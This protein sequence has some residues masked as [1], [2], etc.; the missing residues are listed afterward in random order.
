MYV[1]NAL[2]KMES[3]MHRKILDIIYCTINSGWIKK[4]DMCIILFF[5]VCKSFVLYMF[6]IMIR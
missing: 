1:H 3:L 6:T 4:M 5:S 2:S